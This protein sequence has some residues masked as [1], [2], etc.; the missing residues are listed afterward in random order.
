MSG[1]AY[2]YIYHHIEEAADYTIDLE[3][4]DLF[5]DLAHLLKAEEW[6]MSGDYNKQDWLEKLHA[7]KQK[8]FSGDV[9]ERLQDYIDRRIDETRNELYEMLGGYYA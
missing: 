9:D 4:E 7:F 1:G 6:Y 8:W 2:N 3:I 5:R